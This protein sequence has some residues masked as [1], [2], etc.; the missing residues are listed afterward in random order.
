M[1][2]RK[3][4]Y[5]LNVGGIHTRGSESNVNAFEARPGYRK[6]RFLIAFD[7]HL[8]GRGNC[9]YYCA[10]DRIVVHRQCPNCSKKMF[11]YQ[12]DDHET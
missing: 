2:T 8:V 4:Q 3:V 7:V 1:T 10:L 9:A 6:V 5:L 12:T 11:V